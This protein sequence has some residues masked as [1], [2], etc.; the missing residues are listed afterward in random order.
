[1]KTIFTLLLSAILTTSAFAADEGRLTI[2]VS[3][4]KNVQVVVDNRTYRLDDM[5]ILLY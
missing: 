4:Q 1:M 2:T 5:T 3:T